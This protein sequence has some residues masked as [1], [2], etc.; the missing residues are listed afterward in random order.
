MHLVEE[1][2]AGLV[3]SLSVV[4]FDLVLAALALGN[5]L[6]HWRNLLGRISAFLVLFPHQVVP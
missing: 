4:G 1:R 2:L 5:T 6:D 3:S